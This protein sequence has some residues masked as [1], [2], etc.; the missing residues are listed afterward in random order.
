VG[1]PAKLEGRWV[2]M[3][4]ADKHYDELLRLIN[5][6]TLKENLVRAATYIIAYEFLENML[7]DHVEDFYAIV[8]D[9]SLRSW[10]G[11]GNLKPGEKYK[12]EVRAKDKDDPVMASCRWFE[13]Q[14]VLTSE[15]VEFIKA[16]RK[17]R[18]NLA[19]EMPNVLLRSGEQ[20][21]IQ[22]LNRVCEMAYRLDNWWLVNM[23]DAPAQAQ[24]IG[25]MIL[26]YISEVAIETRSA[27][28]SRSV[29]GPM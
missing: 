15:D 19:H 18:G 10:D 6:D 25:A 24:S 23:E 22:G 16:A 7:K 2:E 12:E 27:D 28:D 17:H 13:E 20:V 11:K 1:H 5:P 4:H 29:P 21:D 8:K 26:R 3:P 14:K 9:G